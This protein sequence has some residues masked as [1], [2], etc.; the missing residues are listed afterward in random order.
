VR[1]PVKYQ[2]GDERAVLNPSGTALTSSKV[3]K[4][5]LVFKVFIGLYVEGNDKAVESYVVDY[6]G[7]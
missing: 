1:W 3:V 6:H 7:E 2:P 4:P 5:P